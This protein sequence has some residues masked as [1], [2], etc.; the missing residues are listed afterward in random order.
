[1]PVLTLT[2]LE[3]VAIQ[4]DVGKEAYSQ[5]EKRLID[6]LETKKSLET[7]AASM[8]ASFTTLALAVAGAGAAFFSS[9]PLVDHA[10]KGLPWIFFITGLL[11]MLGAWSMVV[12]LIP[13]ENGNLGTSP[14][15]W[16]ESGVIDAPS[17]ITPDIQAYMLVYMGERIDKTMAANE[18][19]ADYM[20]QGAFLA[21]SAPLAL[22]L[23]IFCLWLFS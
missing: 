6:L 14:E 5:V 19:K 1:M 18:K 15:I 3:T 22:S 8:L 23:G 20:I 4:P 9:Q 10:H 17:N 21:S 2:Q 12:V 7:R 13:S 11:F 16:L